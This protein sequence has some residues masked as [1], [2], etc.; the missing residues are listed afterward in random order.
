MKKMKTVETQ[1]A[2]LRQQVSFSRIP[3]LMKN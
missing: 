3:A 1:I 2:C